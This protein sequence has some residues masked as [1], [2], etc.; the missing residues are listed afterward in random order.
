M[1]VSRLDRFLSVG[2][3]E[4][5]TTY[6][7]REKFLKLVADNGWTL[8][9]YS[10]ASTGWSGRDQKNDPF[11]LLKPA[12][13]GGT[14]RILLD[15]RDRSSR[16]RCSTD[17][18]LRGVTVEY[19]PAGTEVTTNYYGKPVLEGSKIGH[20]KRPGKYGESSLWEA[21][22]AYDDTVV[23]KA[24]KLVKDPETAVWLAAEA[25]YLHDERMRQ[26]SRRRIALQE[27]RDQPLPITLG[28]GE[29][30]YGSP[31]GVLRG[32]FNTAAR[33]VV[34]A[35]G[36]SD[37][38]RLIAEAQLALNEIIEVLTPEAREALE[39]HLYGKVEL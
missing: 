27:Q 38:P 30:D 4:T 14:W 7:G 15:Y 9:P 18:R 11:A 24:T 31:W 16:S 3:P 2:Y 5:M 10:W 1:S 22:G 33:Q 39:A 23:T 34:E 17:G 28:E 26:E 29:H 37:L 12:L 19:I 36:T 13:D 20:L 25:R 8:D 21:L 32:K 35:D 6:P